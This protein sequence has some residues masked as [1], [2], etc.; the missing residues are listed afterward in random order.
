MPASYPN[1]FSA[2]KVGPL[3]IKNRI[4]SSG[5]MTMLLEA[6]GPSDDMV[7]YHEARAAGGAGLLIT[8]AASIHPSVSAMHILGYS[9]ACIS[10]YRKVADAVH[11]HGCKVFG[12]ISHAGAHNFGSDDGSRPVA[13][14][15]SVAPQE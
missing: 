5:H 10:G 15:P 6:G 8:E 13:Y 2:L 4:F 3:C 9:D 14:G 1:L 12:Q 11:A 7:A